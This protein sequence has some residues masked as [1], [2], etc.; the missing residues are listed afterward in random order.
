MISC[1]VAINEVVNSFLFVL[2]TNGRMQLIV[3]APRVAINE[4][5]LTKIRKLAHT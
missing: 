2:G 5:T 1:S 4:D 3:M